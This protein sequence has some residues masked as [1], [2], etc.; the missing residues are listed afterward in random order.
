[1]RQTRGFTLIELVVAISIIV[2]LTSMVLP[3]VN[4]VR[5]SARDT[6]RL[7]NI[8]ELQNA[9]EDYYDKYGY[10]PG[11]GE[12]GA[13]VPNTGWSNS[14]E[15]LSGGR[16]LRDS[17]SN[18]SEFIKSDPID[19]KQK[20]SI[21]WPG[22]FPKDTYFYFSRGYGGDKQWYMIVFWL[23]KP[24]P[25]LEASDGVLAPDGTVFD[26]GGCGAGILTVGIGK[27]HI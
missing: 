3:A 23:E 8:R 17:T 14:V 22:C 20:S 16:W 7:A 13:V 6:Q 11:S 27:G 9:L 21:T 24:S 10:Y 5:K 18:M 25:E 26:Y 19:P 1:M 12:C 15:C 4:N 2:T